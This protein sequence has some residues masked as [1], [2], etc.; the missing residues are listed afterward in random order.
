MNDLF[1]S[2]TFFQRD[3]ARF[4]AEL[5]LEKGVEFKAS[6]CRLKKIDNE[7]YCELSSMDGNLR[8]ELYVDSVNIVSFFDGIENAICLECYKG[9]FWQDVSNEFKRVLPQVLEGFEGLSS[10]KIAEKVEKRGV[11][12]R[13]FKLFKR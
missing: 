1:A 8:L 9:H 11:S 12:G 3:L 2:R 13:W 7:P 6:F 4:A 5:L 10:G